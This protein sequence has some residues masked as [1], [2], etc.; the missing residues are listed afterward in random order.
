[1]PGRNVDSG[2]A[3]GKI[4]C[5][6]AGDSLGKFAAPL[7]GNAVVAGRGDDGKMPDGGPGIACNAGETVKKRWQD[8][9]GR[10]G[11]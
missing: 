1:M 6:F 3:P 8:N 10:T 9:G 2:A 4:V 7:G 11:A 5:H